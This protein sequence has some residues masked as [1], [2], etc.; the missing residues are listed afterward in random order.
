MASCVPKYYAHVPIAVFCTDA[1]PRRLVNAHTKRS[2]RQEPILSV[3]N[4]P[5]P[6][7]VTNDEFHKIELSTDHYIHSNLTFLHSWRSLRQHPLKL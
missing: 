6:P 5:L 7:Q 2:L 1:V 3:P 4:V